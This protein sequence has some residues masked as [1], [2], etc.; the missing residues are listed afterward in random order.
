MNRIVS[1]VLIF[2]LTGLVGCGHNPPSEN[3]P[4]ASNP[5]QNVARNAQI[6]RTATAQAVSLGLT[7]YANQDRRAEALIVANKI[8][9]MVE[10]T[11][12]PYINGTSG[13]SSAAANGFLTG[14]FVDLPSE[15]QSIISLAAI[16]LDTYL[17]APSADTVLSAEQL[18]YVRAFFQGL[19]DGSEQ[20]SAKPPAQRAAPGLLERAAPASKPA[21]FN[22]DK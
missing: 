16:I 15:V 10:F 18:S 4:T 20:F 13:V 19:N 2:T 22:T 17:P 1:I 21:W 5:S 3:P 12:L 9:G 14:Q 7:I 6:I 8:S 11:A